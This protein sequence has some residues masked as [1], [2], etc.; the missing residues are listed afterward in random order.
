MQEHTVGKEE[1]IEVSNNGN[2]PSALDTLLQW[3]GSLHITKKVRV[4]R[5]KIDVTIRAATM[6]E[7]EK[8]NTQSEYVLRGTRGAAPARETDNI[9]L[10]RITVF[11]C[12]ENPDLNDEKLQLKFNSPGGKQRVDHLIVNSLFLPGEVVMLQ[13][14]IMQ[15]SGFDGGVYMAQGEEENLP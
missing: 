10:G 3:D 5:L 9:K 13:Q 2:I 1:M 15:L 8:Y 4:E 11:N 6:E 14:E 7:M 12:V